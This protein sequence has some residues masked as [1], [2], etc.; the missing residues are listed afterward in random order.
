MV[1]LKSFMANQIVENEGVNNSNSNGVIPT[2]RSCNLIDIRGSQET[3]KKKEVNNS[4]SNGVIPTPKDCDRE[5][6]RRNQEV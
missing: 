5:D 2:L 1:T 3:T 4:N 6:V